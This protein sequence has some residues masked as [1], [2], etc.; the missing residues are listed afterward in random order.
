MLAISLMA[1]VGCI[2]V[3]LT[4]GHVPGTVSFSQLGDPPDH[5]AYHVVLGLFT[6]AT[7]PYAWRAWRA[8]LMLECGFA[9]T[10]LALQA[11]LQALPPATRGH[12]SLA[13]SLTVVSCTL[14]IAIAQRLGHPLVT[15]MAVASF[16]ACTVLFSERDLLI[17]MAENLVL[18]STLLAMNADHSQPLAPRSPPY[19]RTDS[20]SAGWWRIGMGPAMTW[21]LACVLITG[22]CGAFQGLAGGPVTALTCAGAGWMAGRD[23][24]SFWLRMPLLGAIYSGTIVTLAAVGGA[25]LQTESAMPLAISFTT[26]FFILYLIDVHGP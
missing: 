8:G 11:A 12:D 1:L 7:L 17:G 18:A 15:A 19:R 23:D 9:L 25:L 21:S 2:A 20:L 3:Q 26:A 14:A 5:L 24:H 13:C 22:V 6:L 10:A 16:C 4:C